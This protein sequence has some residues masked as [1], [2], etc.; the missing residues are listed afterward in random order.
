[1]SA[2]TPNRKASEYFC[3]PS[4]VEEGE[5]VWEMKDDAEINSIK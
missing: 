5:P 4:S 1:M 2:K 3:A